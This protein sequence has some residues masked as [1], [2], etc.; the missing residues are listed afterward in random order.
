MNSPTENAPDPN[1]LIV[2]I[3]AD[4]RA[5]LEAASDRYQTSLAEFVRQKALEAAEAALEDARLP[6]SNASIVPTAEDHP[7]EGSWLSAL[8]KKVRDKVPPEEWAKM[9]RRS[10]DDIDRKIYKQINKS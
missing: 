8:V 4:E 9:P 2:E 5:L 1:L 6:D 10:S 7:A 3:S